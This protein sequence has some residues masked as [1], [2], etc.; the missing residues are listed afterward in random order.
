MDLRWITGFPTCPAFVSKHGV[1][2]CDVRERGGES[3]ESGA[4][5]TSAAAPH[6]LT[7]FLPMACLRI[8]I[9]AVIVDLMLLTLCR[10]AWAFALQRRYSPLA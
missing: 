7:Y 3:G 10:V 6:V 4:R 5:R 1:R 8:S 2:E 9:A